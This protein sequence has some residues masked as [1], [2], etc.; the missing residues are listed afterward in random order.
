MHGHN[1]G[2]VWISS[3]SRE[4]LRQCHASR[5]GMMPQC[6]A[7]A[8]WLL[9]VEHLA[10]AAQALAEVTRTV[11]GPPP[12]SQAARDT[13]ASLTRQSTGPWW[14]SENLNRM[15]TELEAH[16]IRIEVALQQQDTAAPTAPAAPGRAAT[17]EAAGAAVEHAGASTAAPE[18]RPRGSLPPR[19]AP[20]VIEPLIQHR[21]PAGGAAAAAAPASAAPPDAAEQSGAAGASGGQIVPTDW[22]FAAAE[23]PGAP[24]P[25]VWATDRSQGA[26]SG[27]ADTR[28]GTPRQTQLLREWG[29]QAAMAA[30]PGP[31]PQL[32]QP[33]TVPH[34]ET[35]QERLDFEEERRRANANWEARE[36]W[37]RDQAELEGRRAAASEARRA[38]QATAHPQRTPASAQAS[39]SSGAPAQA[40]DTMQ[41]LGGQCQGDTGGAATAEGSV[42]PPP[43]PPAQQ[44]RGVDA[45]GRPFRIRVRAGLPAVG[46][47][48]E[49]GTDTNLWPRVETPDC[50]VVI[51]DSTRT[52]WQ[53]KM[54]REPSRIRRDGV[55]AEV[56]RPIHVTI[57]AN[58]GWKIIVGDVPRD[59]DAARV[60]L[61]VGTRH[62][63][64]CA[65]A[66]L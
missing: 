33:V 2:T 44:P 45:V 59:L 56:G 66:L 24:T 39:A 38:A 51:A 11:I 20:P 30:G 22:A 6:P 57:D 14:S 26:W 42:P 47:H 46:P 34:F 65:C 15:A 25:S 4:R 29:Q 8:A 28:P 9:A 41:W 52:R 31:A 12:G 10:E 63:G 54:G 37:M 49:E 18:W 50:A 48:P 13:V 3:S 23:G 53:Q 62:C 61:S 55:W 16:A 58:P 64:R 60:R 5:I 21:G 19:A 1:R 40:A 7:V 43:A 17:A 32:G 36:K 27:A 35:E